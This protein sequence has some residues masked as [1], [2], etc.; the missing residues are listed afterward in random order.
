MIMMMMMIKK[1]YLIFHSTIFK[2]N[3]HTQTQR[4][5]LILALKMNEKKI[6]Y[7]KKEDY[8]DA[9]ATNFSL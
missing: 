4:K 5:L 2:K 6:P 8:R 3:T 9:A 1:N 7:I